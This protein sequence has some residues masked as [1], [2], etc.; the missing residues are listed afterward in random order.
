V[1]ALEGADMKDFRNLTARGRALRLRRLA[2]AALERY[3]LEVERVRLLTNDFNGIFRV[4]AENGRKYVLRITLP[5]GGHSLE[6]IRS[7][8]MWL[9]AL[10]RD[11]GLSVPSPLATRDGALVT[12]V[13]ADGI[14]EA[15]HCVVFR[16][17][18]GPDLADRLTMENAEKL[19]ALAAQ[20][21]NHAETFTPPDGFWLRTKDKVFPYQEPVVLFDDVYCDL[22]PVGRREIF[23]VAAERVQG[24]LDRLAAGN[25]G[26]LVIHNDLHQWNVKVFRG[27]VYPLDFEDLMWG[28]PVQDIAVT[29]YYFLGCEAYGALR[30][31]FK[32]GYTGHREWPEQL[33]GEI[34]A[35]IG[36]RALTL[37]NLIVQD[38]MPEWQQQAPAFVE[39]TE[40]RLRA[41]LE[42]G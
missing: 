12:V 1:G 9:A 31:A 15:R 19:G 20:L 33:P 29:L 13:E 36:G 16:W 32:R 8:M 2:V 18:P 17:A 35:F 27:E 11:T 3:A 39:R 28:Y 10:R 4:D 42:T 30:Q 25:V 7:E 21:H 22:V 40:A 5:E 24:A 26:R 14:P 38:P 34:D 23:H 6:E 37:A 41:L